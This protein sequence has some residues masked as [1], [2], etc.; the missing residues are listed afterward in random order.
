MLKGIKQII[1]ANGR[2][3]FPTTVLYITL[4]QPTFHTHNIRHRAWL[5]CAIDPPDLG[6]YR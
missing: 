1:Y 6:Q 5:R 4:L 2:R 3:I